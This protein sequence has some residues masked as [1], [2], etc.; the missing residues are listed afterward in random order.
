MI[1]WD[2]NSSVLMNVWVVRVGKFELIRPNLYASLTRREECSTLSTWEKYSKLDNC[3]L[4]SSLNSQ[5]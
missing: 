5:E 1:R 4:W 2:K 3:G